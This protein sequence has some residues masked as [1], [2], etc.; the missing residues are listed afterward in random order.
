MNKNHQPMETSDKSAPGELNGKGR[1]QSVEGEISFHEESLIL[2][3]TNLE[4]LAQLNKEF[5]DLAD[6]A[7]K[8]S[9]ERIM[10]FKNKVKKLLLKEQKYS[11]KVGSKPIEFV[12]TENSLPFASRSADELQEERS[13]L[14]GSRI[15]KILS[16][17]D[18]NSKESQ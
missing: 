3:K 18:G 8:S 12:D 17:V 10:E 7:E 1:T 15:E 11:T 14:E 6:H 4:S 9:Y 13:S 5:Q 2:E 16:E